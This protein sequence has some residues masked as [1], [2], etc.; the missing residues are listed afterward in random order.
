MKKEEFYRGA[1]KDSIG[2]LEG[3]R[4]LE[5]T[6]VAAGPLAGTLLA[7]L[8][9][10]SVRCEMPGRGDLLRQVTH[11]QV[12]GSS[13]LDRSAY[14]LSVNR[15]KKSIT[16]NLKRPEGQELFRKLAPHVDVIIENFKP[17]TMKSWGLSYEDI[18]K[19]K[20]DIIYTSVSGYG[21]YGPY[22]HRPGY[23][24]I[25][26]AMGGLMSITGY[27]DGPPTKTGHAI[28]DNLGGWQGAFGTLAALIYRMK[29]GKGQHVDV[30]LVDS[31]LYT[32][33]FGIMGAANADWHWERTGNRHPL[34]APS[35]TF[36]CRDGWVIMSVA[37]DSQWERL[38]R[39]M[40]R[41]DLI[42]QSQTASSAQRAENWSFV[43][44]TVA[45]WTQQRT[46][47]QVVDAFEEAGLV[48]SPILSFEEI[49]QDPHFQ[50]R[51][52]VAE[53]N[54]PTAGPL[55]LFGV[56]S[57]YSLTPGR[58]RTPAPLLGQHNA[59]IYGGWL[60]LGG[61]EMQRLKDQGVI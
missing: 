53:V 1:L 23:D 56:A 15:N 17:G 52:M 32:T 26:Q 28:A 25:G 51:E 44:D 55:K 41:E 18:R 31:T 24:H 60:A 30:N 33:T 47:N 45:R 54:H 16:L 14:Y 50:E 36:L 19:V 2:P 20:P 10:E 8:G 59:E 3:I 7:D 12:P 61:K 37:S 48:A 35:N 42:G 49:L 21:Q 29:T 6:N 4:I 39:L 9:A 40:N 27:P 11:C 38:C 13:E 5:A 22:S 43:E 58:V 46:V 57:K 34:N